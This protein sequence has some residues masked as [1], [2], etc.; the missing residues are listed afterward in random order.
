MINALIEYRGLELHE[1]RTNFIIL[2]ER[3]FFV[4]GDADEDEA[5]LN[6]HNAR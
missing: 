2:K 5:E 6:L 1:A 3:C 4:N